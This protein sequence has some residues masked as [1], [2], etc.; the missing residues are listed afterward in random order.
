M[1]RRYAMDMMMRMCCMCMM[2]YAQNA[3]DLSSCQTA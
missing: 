3:G 1:N 2:R